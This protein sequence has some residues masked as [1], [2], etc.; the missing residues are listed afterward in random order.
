MK[1]QLARAAN[2]LG[3]ALYMVFRE[4][5]GLSVCMLLSTSVFPGLFACAIVWP[6]V[7]LLA[8]SIRF[9]CGVERDAT[10]TSGGSAWFSAA[11]KSG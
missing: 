8:N 3:S 5:A 1:G 4:V 6:H 2:D 9:V 7:V 10:H 11:G